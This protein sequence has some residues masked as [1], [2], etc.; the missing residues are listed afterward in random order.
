MSSDERTSATTTVVE[1][2]LLQVLREVEDMLAD[3]TSAYWA[4]DGGLEPIQR[5]RDLI[6]RTLAPWE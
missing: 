3:A 1:R 6:E 4:G 2:R 5:A